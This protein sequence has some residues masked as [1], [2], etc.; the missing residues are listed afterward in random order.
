VL[1]GKYIL[2]NILGTPPSPPPPNVDTTLEQ[3]QGEEPKSMRALLERHRAN[4]TCASCHRVMDPLGFALENFDG[5]GEFRRKE[6]AGAIDS[7]GQLGDGTPVNGPA[8][9]RAAIMKRPEMF[10]RTLT[11]KLMTYGLGRAVEAHDKPMV[12]GIARD[13]A[14]QNYRFSTVVLGI[15]KS[16]PF[17][18]KKAAG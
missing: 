1:R 5:V 7:T 14:K 6:V 8:G 3:K 9:L 16:A 10:V 15:V 13:V 18:M 17:Q 2:E 12:R 4:P 11:Q